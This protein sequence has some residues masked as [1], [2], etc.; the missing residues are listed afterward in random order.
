MSYRYYVSEDLGVE[1]DPNLKR[2]KQSDFD[3][4]ADAMALFSAAVAEGTTEYI[5]IEALLDR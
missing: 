2:F 5:T 4:P 3:N 1:R